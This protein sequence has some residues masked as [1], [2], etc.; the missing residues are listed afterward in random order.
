MQT[1]LLKSGPTKRRSRG[2]PPLV[3]TE[4]TQKLL[5]ELHERKERDEEEKRVKEANIMRHKC[6]R[7]VNGYCSPCKFDCPHYRAGK[8]E[9]IEASFH[10]ATPANPGKASGK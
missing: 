9:D 2:D 1:G 6:E 3:F 7:L 10:G 4:E 5:A 8:C